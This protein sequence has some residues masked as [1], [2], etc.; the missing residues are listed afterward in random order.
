[1]ATGDLYRVNVNIAVR[2]TQTSF[3]LYYEEITPDPSYE[4]DADNIAK[5]WWETLGGGLKAIIAADS[6]VSNI[7]ARRVRGNV[8]NPGYYYVD[9]GVGLVA[10]ESL[11]A[12]NGMRIRLLQDDRPGRFNG[13]INVPGVPLI[14]ID[15]NNLTAD[16][17]VA[18]KA[19]FADKL[20]DPISDNGETTGVWV[21]TTVTKG[22]PL[23]DPAT[24]VTSWITEAAP[25]SAIRSQSRRRSVV[26]E[27]PLTVD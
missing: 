18:I 6:Y 2:N 7:Y 19:A 22:L 9:D 26:K 27:F 5:A 17:I 1:M 14:S 12:S 21:P 3:G 8:C 13:A 20:A 16:F 10:G 25:L 24:W 4:E 11:T 23:S 15:G